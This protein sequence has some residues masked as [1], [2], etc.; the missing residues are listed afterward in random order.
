M[1]EDIRLDIPER[2]YLQWYGDDAS[3]VDTE[4]DGAVDMGDVT[5]HSE[6]VF[7]TDIEYVRIDLVRA[8]KDEVGK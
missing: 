3:H 8:L 4:T 7:D 6:R 1:K 5:W 2:M